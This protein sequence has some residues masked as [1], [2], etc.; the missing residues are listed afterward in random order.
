MP[1]KLL[2]VAGESSG[3]LYGSLL[4]SYLKEDFELI[5]LGGKH[6]SRAGIK[7]IGE[8]THSFGV[9][10]VV[11]QLRKIKKNMDVAIKALKD[12]Q[13]VILIDF[14]DFNLRLAKKAKQSGKKVLYYV[15]PQIWAWR[16]GRLN[17]IKRVVDY[18]AVVL[19]FEEEIYK[20]A[21]I[22]AQFVGHPIFEA[23]IEELKSDSEDFII[24]NKKLLKDKFGIKQDNIIT[25]MPG[26]RPSEIKMKMPLMLSLINY[27][28]RQKTH[29]IIPKAPNV[30]FN[31]ETLK[32]LT[33]F[34]NV[35]IFNEQ[36][37]TALA[38]SDAAVITSGTSTLQATLLKVPMIVIYRVNPFSYIIGKMFIKGVKHIALPNVIADFMNVGDTRVTEFIQKI[39]VVKIVENIN[40]LLHDTDYRGKIINFLDN[41]RRYF[42]NKKAS[43]NVAEICKQLF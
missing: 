9:L 13:G 37:Y 17:I 29:F 31:E 22:P 43:E 26:S 2:I 12:V 20:K 35:T 28:D 25:L 36:S 11:S 15:S 33:S 19:P 4:A 27:F 10:E 24:Q 32:K 21:G 40:L 41:I 5:G 14:P 7:L 8:V 39:D 30:E 34:G 16:K 1:P 3:E 6:M 38:M 42:I 18:M 23:M